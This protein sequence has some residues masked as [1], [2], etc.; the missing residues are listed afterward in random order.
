GLLDVQM[1]PDNTL[2]QKNLAVARGS[3]NVLEESSIGFIATHG[4]PASTGDN[5][6]DGFDLTYRNAH[7]LGNH[8]FE[9][10]AFAM[11][12]HST[13]EDTGDDNTFGFHLDYPND[14]W[15]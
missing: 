9:A 3:V 14:D 1:Y 4:D 10:T 12:S 15:A 8:V 13:L 6:L 7:V 11:A 2:G 5:T